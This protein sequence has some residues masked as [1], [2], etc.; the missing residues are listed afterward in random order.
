MRLSHFRDRHVFVCLYVQYVRPHL[1]FAVPAWFPWLKGDKEALEKVQK[2]QGKWFLD[3]KATLIQR[4]WRKPAF[5]P[6]GE[7]PLGS[8]GADIKNWYRKRHSEQ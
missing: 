8:H 4:G 7:A 1:E 3:L 5:S 6:L 2:G